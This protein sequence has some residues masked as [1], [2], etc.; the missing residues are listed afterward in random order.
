M[1]MLI[2]PR[3]IPRRKITKM[4]RRKLEHRFLESWFCVPLASDRT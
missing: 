1:T 4:G 2:L 3:C